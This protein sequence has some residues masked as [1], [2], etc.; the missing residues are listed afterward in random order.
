M[1]R[2]SRS[3]RRSPSSSACTSALRMSSRGSVRRCATI[4][5]KYAS[6]SRAACVATARSRGLTVGS[7]RRARWSDHSLNRS[8]SSAGTPSIP[9]TTMT[10][11]GW[12]SAVMRSKPPASSTS[13]RSAAVVARMRASMASIAREVNALF[14]SALSRVWSGGSSDSMVSSSGGGSM[15][16]CRRVSLPLRGSLAKVRWSRRIASASAWR[17]N[18]QAFA[19]RLRCTGSR[20]R[21][22]A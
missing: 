10:G 19:S 20:L 16:R 5:R 17:E 22:V 18:S 2:V 15:A 13:S 9:A 12:A 7:S 14:T 21:R 4:D 3:V 1:L 6:N 11:R 8:R